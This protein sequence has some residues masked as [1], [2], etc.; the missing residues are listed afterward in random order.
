MFPPDPEE[1]LGELSAARAGP[2]HGLGKTVTVWTRSPAQ[3][4]ASH[5]SAG[6]AGAG[7]E[8]IRAPPNR[9]RTDRRNEVGEVV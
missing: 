7:C 4:P 2:R 1:K 3:T 9:G 6:S 5:D 8:E